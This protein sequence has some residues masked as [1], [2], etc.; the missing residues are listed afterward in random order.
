MK[1]K[2]LLALS[3]IVVLTVLFAISVSAAELVET[4]DISATEN[5]SVTANLYSDGTLDIVGVGEIMDEDYSKYPYGRFCVYDVKSIMINEG[6]TGIGKWIFSSLNVETV[7]L[8]NTLITIGNGAFYHCRNLKEVIIP[9]GVKTIGSDAFYE[10]VNL[11]RV[12]IGEGV[13]N[14]GSAAF[15]ST[16][17]EVLFLPKSVLEIGQDAFCY[18]NLSY[19][20]IFIEA[21]AL[22]SGWIDWQDA[23]PDWVLGYASCGHVHSFDPIKCIC[24]KERILVEKFD[25]SA[26]ENDNVW[27]YLYEDGNINSCYMVYISGTGNTKSVSPWDSS[28]DDKIVTAV[29]ETGVT[30]FGEMFSGL[31]NLKSVSLPVGIKTIDENAFNYCRSLTSIV[32]PTGVVSIGNSA[33][34][35]CAAMT[36]VVIPEGVLTIGD[37]AFYSCGG[38][39]SVKLPK[40]VTSV[41]AEAFFNCAELKSIELSEGINSIG[42]GAFGLCKSLANIVIPRGV[43]SIEK[44]TFSGCVS[45][46]SIE[47]PAKVVSI[48]RAAFSSCKSLTTIV[49]PKGVESIGERVFAYCE[50]LQSIV[51]AEENAFY[52]SIDGNLYTKDGKNLIQYAVGK[53]SATFKV[54]AGVTNIG[55]EAFYYC[56][57][58]T[59][60][61]LPQGMTSIGS[62]AFSYCKGLTSITMP[63]SLTSIESSAFFYC[64]S[65]L[66]IEIPDGIT[67]IGYEAF[68]YCSSLT[69]IVIP[70]SVTCLDYSVFLQCKNLFVYCEAESQPEGWHT[71]WNYSNTPVVWGYFDA[72]ACLDRVF[73]FKGYSFSESGAI[74]VGFDIDYAAMAK[75][76]AKTGKTLEI[77][78][79]FA[80][81][82]NLGGKQPLDENGEAIALSVGR[83][84]KADLTGFEYVNYDFVLTDVSDSIKDVKLVIAA[85]IYDGEIVKYVQENGISDTV[86]GI[87]YNEAKESVV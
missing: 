8:P 42:N 55:K 69:S 50:N 79:L 52:K 71:R 2:F 66:S 11:S 1:K 5:D 19:D 59:S 35:Y 65:L 43:T 16:A 87:S 53:E 21:E 72:N 14:I 38:L 28:Y 68:A 57:N 18:T 58:L 22:P 15:F 46:T 73:T 10:C 45:L 9:N 3:M 60:V 7:S 78:V 74:A 31:S 39:T 70:E 30:G 84:V 51:V 47:I 62:S 25:V 41:G 56:T 29:V 4:W 67:N 32:I 81:Y 26:T 64:T 85:Y 33:F 20:K 23:A 82:D 13:T 76:E 37:N 40:S 48:G 83:V 17:I 49:I 27:A 34:Y 86:S 80:G 12:T 36:S 75:Y 63:R 6:V 24:G 54:P 77:G 61:E 44:D